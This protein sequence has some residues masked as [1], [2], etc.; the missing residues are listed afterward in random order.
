MIGDFIGSDT[1][2]PFNQYIV[3]I[4]T[5]TDPYNGIVSS[6]LFDIRYGINNLPNGLNKWTKINQLKTK[7]FYGTSG[8]FEL[9]DTVYFPDQANAY[10]NS[11]GQ[12]II[13]YL[14]RKTNPNNGATLFQE[15]R[16]FVGFKI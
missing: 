14:Y 5:F 9:G 15:T 3:K 12:L 13:N 2:Y 1:D 6:G 4:D 8:G 16:T 11:S 7:G 10:I